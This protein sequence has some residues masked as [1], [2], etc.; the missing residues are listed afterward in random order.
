MPAH[1]SPIEALKHTRWWEPTVKRYAAHLLAVERHDCPNLREKFI[2]FA[3]EVLNTPEAI[4]DDLLAMPPLDPYVPRVRYRAYDSPT[5][6][7]LKAVGVYQG[8][9]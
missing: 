2:V 3:A 5:Q 6:A 4:R 9:K 8:R 1:K 7:E